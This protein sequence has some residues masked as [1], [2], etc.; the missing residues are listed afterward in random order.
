MANCSVGGSNPPPTAIFFRRTFKDLITISKHN[1]P[2]SNSPFISLIS[3][4]IVFLYVF[5]KKE[6]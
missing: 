6:C 1:P 2:E 4:I 5:V 3:F